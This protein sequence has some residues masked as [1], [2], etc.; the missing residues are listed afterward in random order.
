[1]SEKHLLPP[2]VPQL[3]RT[4]KIMGLAWAILLACGCQTTLEDGYKPKSLD[5][6]PDVRKSFYASPFSDSAEAGAKDQGPSF[7]PG[8]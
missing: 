1:M 7:R 8:K 4:L 3:R 2:A 6:S 5:A